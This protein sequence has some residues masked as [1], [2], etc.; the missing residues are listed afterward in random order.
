MQ[1]KGVIRFF[2]IALAL[3]SLVQFLFMLP[4]RKVERRADDYAKRISAN[5]PTDEQAA[6]YKAARTGFLDSMSSE[7]VLKLPLIPGLS[8]QDLKSNQVA[9]GLDLKGGMSVVLQVDLRD[10]IRSLSNN[11]EDPTLAQALEKASNSLANTQ[12]DYVT[13]F[14]RSCQNSQNPHAHDTAPVGGLS[15]P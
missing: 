7:T 3:V 13:L 9:L 8:Y 5:A 14:G 6:A 12:L 15:C 4:T 1:G 11:A 2:L 10:L